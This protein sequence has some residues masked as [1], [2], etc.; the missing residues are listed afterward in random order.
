MYVKFRLQLFVMLNMKG[1]LASAQTPVPPQEDVLCDCQAC[2]MISGGKSKN[3]YD[4]LKCHFD[5]P[6]PSLFKAA[7]I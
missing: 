6:L 1:R 2:K 3:I 4:R 5:S 7:K